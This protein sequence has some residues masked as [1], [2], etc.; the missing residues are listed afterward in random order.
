MYRTLT[1]ALVFSSLSTIVLAQDP[2]TPP[3]PP[4]KPAPIE[5]RYAPNRPAAPPATAVTSPAPGIW[6]RSTPGTEVKTVATSA[7]S[8]ELA[9]NNG[10]AN[11]TLRHP[12]EDEQILVD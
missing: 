1:L 11:I 3:A 2:S 10:L 6:V 8:I 7:D 5:H 4:Q 12:K 9:V